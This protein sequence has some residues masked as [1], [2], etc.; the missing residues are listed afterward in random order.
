V[1]ATPRQVR[2][3]SPWV[4]PAGDQLVLRIDLDGRGGGDPGSGDQG[5]Q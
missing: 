4:A 1:L 5:Q 2:P 3:V